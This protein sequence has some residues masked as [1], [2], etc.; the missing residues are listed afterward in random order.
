MNCLYWCL[1][2]YRDMKL[3]RLALFLQLIAVEASTSSTNALVTTQTRYVVDLTTD[4]FNESV[5]NGS[6]FIMFYDP[7]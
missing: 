2:I 1:H 7:T 4:S 3:E 6:H 5:A